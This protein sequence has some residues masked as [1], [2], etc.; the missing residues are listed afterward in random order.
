MREKNMKL[1]KAKRDRPHE[2]FESMSIYWLGVF[3][4]IYRLL[5]EIIGKFRMIWKLLASGQNKIIQVFFCR[6]KRDLGGPIETVGIVPNYSE[7]YPYG[8]FRTVDVGI[9]EFMNIN[10]PDSQSIDVIKEMRFG[11][12]EIMQQLGVL[13]IRQE[14]K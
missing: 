5:S 6:R 12:S 10:I 2:H 11:E 1:K 9:D 14:C 13:E 7:I 4:I 3:K 8:C